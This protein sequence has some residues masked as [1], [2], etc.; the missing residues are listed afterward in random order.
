MGASIDIDGAPRGRTNAKVSLPPGR[1]AVSVQ[2][3]KESGQFV[4]DVE[5]GAENKWCFVVATGRATEGSC[6]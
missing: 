5:P 3:G 2:S 6:P 4:I 1:H